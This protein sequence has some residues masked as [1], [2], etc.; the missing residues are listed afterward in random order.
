MIL[1]VGGRGQ[2]KLALALREQGLD[3]A[4]VWDGA[5]CP[6]GEFP[7]KPVLNHL[8]RLIRRLMQAGIDP[9][10]YVEMLAARCPELVVICDEVGC[11]VV[12]IEASERQWREAVGRACC[13]LAAKSR[14]VVRVVAGL[15][16]TLKEI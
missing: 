6:L 5:V 7:P 16:Q 14:R 3:P 9:A 10:G 13:A 2:G 8:H 4:Q 12:P 15:P 11:G 1:Y